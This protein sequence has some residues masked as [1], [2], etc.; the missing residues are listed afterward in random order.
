VWTGEFYEF[1]LRYRMA[2][3]LSEQKRFDHDIGLI[4]IDRLKMMASLD[5]AERRMPQDGRLEGSILKAEYRINIIPCI[6]GEKIVLRVL[7]TEVRPQLSQLGISELGLQALKRAIANHSGLVVIAGSTGS[8]KTTTLHALLAEVDSQVLNIMTLEHPVEYRFAGLTQVPISP[9]LSFAT[10]L[11]ALLRQDPDV[12]L[13]GEIR[14]QETAKLALDAAST[15]H[16]VLT[17]LHANAPE[18]VASRLASRGV[19]P[20]Q[21]KRQL[22]FAG[23][24]RLIPRDGRLHMDFSWRESI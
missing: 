2:G 10:G 11:R 19:C 22:R 4:L 16:L 18:D 12:I 7:R 24:Q 15:G 23:F 6:G 17:S 3:L 21:L 5:V 20:D 13:V 14:D 8:G 1:R 9:N